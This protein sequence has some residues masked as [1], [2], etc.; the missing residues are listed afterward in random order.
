MAH[1]ESMIPEFDDAEFPDDA[2]IPAE[3]EE[4]NINMGATVSR[5]TFQFA[6]GNIHGPLFD[7]PPSAFSQRMPTRIRS[8]RFATVPLSGPLFV[9]IPPSAFS[10]LVARHR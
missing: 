10:Q 2:E 3:D 7:L 9:D 5:G 4:H 6:T 8:F 1:Y